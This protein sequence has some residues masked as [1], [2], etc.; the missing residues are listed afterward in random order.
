VRRINFLL[1][2]AG[3]TREAA[4]KFPRTAIGTATTF[5]RYSMAARYPVPHA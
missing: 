3:A 4:A 2:L 1:Q 5:M